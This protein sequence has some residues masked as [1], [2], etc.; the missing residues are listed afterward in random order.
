MNTLTITQEDIYKKFSNLK[1][2]KSPGLDMIHPRVLFEMR[3]VIK[4]PL[5]LMY[6]KSLQLGVLPYKWKLAKVTAIYKKGK[7]CN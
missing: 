7:K 4:Y 1:T 2:D 6:S 3:D 5:F